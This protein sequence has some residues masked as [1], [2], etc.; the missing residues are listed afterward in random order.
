LDLESHSL[1]VGKIEETHIS[2]SCLTD[3]KPDISKI[4]PLTYITAPALQYQGL[5]EVIAKA[6]ITGEELKARE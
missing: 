3:G 6:Y 2:E 4:K 5:G 1:I